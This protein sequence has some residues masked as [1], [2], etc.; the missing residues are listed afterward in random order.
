MDFILAMILASA[1][2]KTE[3][4]YNKVG[5]PAP[6][7]EHASPSLVFY[8]RD[9]LKSEFYA[10]SD[11][12]PKAFDFKAEEDDS[13]ADYASI[14][15]LS[16]L[17]YAKHNENPIASVD[18]VPLDPDSDYDRQNMLYIPETNVKGN[19][20]EKS[21]P[22]NG[23]NQITFN[24]TASNAIPTKNAPQYIT[25]EKAFY[26]DARP[27][28]NREYRKFVQAT[29]RKTPAH[30]QNSSLTASMK[31]DP[32][33]NVTYEDAKAYAAWLGRRLPSFSEMERAIK[34]NPA[35]RQGAPLR[36]WTSSVANNDKIAPHYYIIGG[37][38]MEGATFDQQTGF[39]TAIDD[40]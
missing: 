21:Q 39:R 32:V 12:D 26:I 20:V 11:I 15:F 18:R 38:E 9:E 3:V 4:T 23:Y 31:N 2:L 35:I 16:K 13:E 22:F 33:V 37:K 24:K 8:V 27:V 6:K 14:K 17:L 19:P 1:G 7:I 30:W 5:V 10:M 40:N 34:E 25:H 36:E 29:G 28:T